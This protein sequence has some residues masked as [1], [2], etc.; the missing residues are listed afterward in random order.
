MTTTDNANAY[1]NILRK[2]VLPELDEIPGSNGAFVL[3]REVDD[4]VEFITLT[5]FDSLDAVKSFAG[6]EYDKAVILP[7]AKALLSTYEFTATHYEIVIQPDR[8]SGLLDL[9]DRLDLNRG[10]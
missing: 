10:V 1:E 6:E 8:R 7:E 5:L 9:K 4:G 2:L 3:R